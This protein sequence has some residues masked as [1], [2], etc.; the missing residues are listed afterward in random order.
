[1]NHTQAVFLGHF[2]P[3]VTTFWLWCQYYFIKRKR[4][5]KARQRL[6]AQEKLI[7]YQYTTKINLEVE[8]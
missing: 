6:Q 8:V 2:I 4:A 1:V 5:R 7:Q 3:M